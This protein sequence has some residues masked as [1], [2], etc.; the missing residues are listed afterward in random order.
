MHS[1]LVGQGD[2]DGQAIL[3]KADDVLACQGSKTNGCAEWALARGDGPPVGGLD[4][5]EQ[6]ILRFHLL[7][8][9]FGQLFAVV[10]GG[11]QSPEAAQVAF[12]PFFGQFGGGS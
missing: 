10:D 3:L 1:C 11:H 4:Q 7:Q 12:H 5:W 6:G 2:V 8:P 9:A